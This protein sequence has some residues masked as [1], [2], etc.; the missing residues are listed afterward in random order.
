MSSLEN[1]LAGAPEIHRYHRNEK[2]LFHRTK[3]HPK[4]LAYVP[5]RMIVGPQ[6]RVE[7]RCKF[8]DLSQLRNRPGITSRFHTVSGMAR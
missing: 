3:E 5:G 8:G 7:F 6:P 1:K 4:G 2:I